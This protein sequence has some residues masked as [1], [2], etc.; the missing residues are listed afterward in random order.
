MALATLCRNNTQDSDSVSAS[1]GVA[2]LVGLLVPGGTDVVREQAA[3]ALCSLC[4]KDRAPGQ[5][6]RVQGRRDTGRAAGAWHDRCRAR[7]GRCGT[8]EPVL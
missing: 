4:L 2:A 8:A 7:T 5:R 6:A 3:A 1:G